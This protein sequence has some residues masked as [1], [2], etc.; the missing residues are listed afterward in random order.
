MQFKTFIFG[1]VTMVATVNACGCDT[2][3]G[4]HDKK[5]SQACCESVRGDWKSD[6]CDADSMSES[7]RDYDKCC[8]AEGLMSSCDYP[9]PLGDIFG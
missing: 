2:S 5:L 7:L 3:S 6:D 4:T 9:N 8:Q 1:L